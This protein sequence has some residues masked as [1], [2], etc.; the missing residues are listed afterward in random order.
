M[1][2]R[3]NGLLE[4]PNRLRTFPEKKSTKKQAEQGGKNL[5]DNK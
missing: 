5:T 1:D 2:Q 4:F 3:K